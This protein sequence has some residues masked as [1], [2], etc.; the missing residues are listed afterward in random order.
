MINNSIFFFLYSFAHRSDFLD[1]EIVFLAQTLP[2][3]VIV[4]AMLFL[5]F[6]HDAMPKKESFRELKAFFKKWKEIGLVFFSGILAW[7]LASLFKNLFHTL[8]PFDVFTNVHSLISESGFAFPSGHATFYGA[9]AVS[10]Y[11]CHKKAGHVF[12]IFALL[13]GIARIVAGVHSPIDILGGFVLGSLIAV[14]MNRIIK[15]K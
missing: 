7:C 12:I 1:K 8:R 13:I 4:L 11:F 9:L 6:H 10:I 15:K 14:G 5:I 2:Y 3:I